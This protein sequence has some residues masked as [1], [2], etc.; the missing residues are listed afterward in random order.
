[1]PGGP[2]DAFPRSTA[3]S[4]GWQWRIP[5]QHRMGNGLVYSSAHLERGQAEETLLA[6]LESEPLADPRPLSFTAGRRRLAWNGNVVSLGLSSGFIEP[7]ESTSIH[8]I[9]SGIA[10]LIALFPD[11]RFNRA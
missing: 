3:R 6:N 5:L 7:L 2:P 10:K 8:L 11:R 1:K 4:A 9:Q